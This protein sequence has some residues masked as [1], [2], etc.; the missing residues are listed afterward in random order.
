MEGLFVEKEIC[1]KLQSKE[2]P[3]YLK[4]ECFVYKRIITWDVL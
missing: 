4:E 3:L 2:F 1:K